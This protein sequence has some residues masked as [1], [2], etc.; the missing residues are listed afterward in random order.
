MFKN[1]LITFQ[2][3]AF[4]VCLVKWKNSP[5]KIFFYFAIFALFIINFG[6][7]KTISIL[8]IIDLLAYFIICINLFIPILNLYE[9]F[10]ISVID[11]DC[12]GKLN[13]D[14]SIIKDESESES[15]TESKP[16]IPST[17]RLITNI[18]TGAIV[19]GTQIGKYTPSITIDK[20][21][22]ITVVK[23]TQEPDN[24]INEIIELC[25]K[26]WEGICLLAENI[27][28]FE[29]R[30]KTIKNTKEVA[31]NVK[32]V[33]DYLIFYLDE[34]I[35]GFNSIISGSDK[36]VLIKC[37]LVLNLCSVVLIFIILEKIFKSNFVERFLNLILSK[38]TFI[39]TSNIETI[40]FYLSRYKNIQI[41]IFDYGFF[42]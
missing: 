15:S 24:I 20:D 21:P 30:I 41:K 18:F 12:L 36:E 42:L 33:K 14:L 37:L 11:Y 26:L 9:I 17:V 35:N 16:S 34:S 39:S 6:Y 22:K 25:D 8:F 2:F 23:E 4:L 38:K 29:E 40:K 32:D 19:T 1:N 27:A 5:L 28:K 31:D 3:R 13:L 10:E 7:F